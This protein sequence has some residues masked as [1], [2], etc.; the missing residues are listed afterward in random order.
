MK[1]TLKNQEPNELKNYVTTNP[2]RTWD[3]FKRSPARRKAVQLQLATDQSGICAYCEINLK[4]ADHTGVADFRVEHFH[5]KS[6]ASTPKNWHLDWQNLLAVCHGGSRPDVVEAMSRF[7]ALHSCDVPKG[8]NDWDAVILNPLNLTSDYCLFKFDRSTGGMQVN[9]INCNSAAVCITKAKAT[10]DNLQLDSPR[11]R[12]L[13]KPA[14][15]K[16][17]DQLKLLV[18]NG[19]SLEDARSYLASTFL[20]K[21]SNHHWPAFF[22]AIR[23][24]LGN[25]AEAHLKSTGYIG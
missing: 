24:Y 1:N 5:P 14:L 10:V 9:E 16:L 6:D 4:A 8:E 7:T 22:S 15:D 11:L 18:D 21:D 12:K 17:N 13:R 25:H 3:H 19:R 20:I 2:T 23:D